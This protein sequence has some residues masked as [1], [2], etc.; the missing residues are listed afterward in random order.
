VRAYTVK[1]NDKKPS[2]PIA[3]DEKL[4]PSIASRMRPFNDPFRL[5]EHGDL[6]GPWLKRSDAIDRIT[7]KTL[8]GAVGLA[9]DLRNKAGKGVMVRVIDVRVPSSITNANEKVDAWF[10][11]LDTNC[12]PGILNLGCTVCKSIGSTGTRSQHSPW[13]Q[14]SATQAKAAGFSS[15]SVTDEGNAGDAAHSGGRTAMKKM[16]EWS[17]ANREDLGIVN[18]IHWPIGSPTPLIWNEAGGIHVYNTPPGGSNHSDHVHADFEPSRP[19]GTSS[20]AC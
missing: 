11:G 12:G 6:P 18:L 1:T 13:S 2:S 15:A 17:Y 19:S 14:L 8:H 9:T 4:R 16:W 20:A 7:A 10:L 3:E 5:R